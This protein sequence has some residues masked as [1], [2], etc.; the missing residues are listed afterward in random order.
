M[1]RFRLYMGKRELDKVLHEGTTTN[2]GNCNLYSTV[3]SS[4]AFHPHPR[5]TTSTHYPRPTTFSYTRKC[6]NIHGHRRTGNFLPGVAVDHLPKKI[7]QVPQIFT[8]EPKRNEDHIAT[9]Q[10]VLAYEGGSIQFFRVN[11]RFE[12]KLRRHKQ[13]LGK[14]A[15]TVDENLS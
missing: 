5:P 4:F 9:T 15:T 7:S 14:I 10:P 1:L 2:D 3:P 6:I 11:T 8:K 13:T 12:H